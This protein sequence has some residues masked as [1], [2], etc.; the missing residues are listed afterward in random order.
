MT[1]EKPNITDPSEWVKIYGDILYAYALSRVYR[2]E[3]AEDLVQETF[4]SAL[5]SRGNFRGQSSEQTWMISILKNKII[6]HY[7][8]LGNSREKMILDKNWET[9]GE[10]SPFQKE[11]PLK[12]HWIKEKAP[13]SYGNSIEKMIDSR[14][15]QHIL[16]LCL[17]L[18]PEKWAAAFTLKVMEEFESDEVCKDLGISSSNLWVIMHRARLKIR[19]CLEKRWIEK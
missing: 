16:E 9:S 6:D 12:G 5:K 1:D 18:L 3:L 2:R 8:K 19:D 4:L 17:S 10:E 11:G 13:G 14:E 15:F 7:R